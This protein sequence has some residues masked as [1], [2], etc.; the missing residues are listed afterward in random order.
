MQFLLTL[1]DKEKHQNRR[2]RN[3]TVPSAATKRK[4][5]D[6]VIHCYEEQNAGMYSDI[7][8]LFNQRHTGTARK[9]LYVHANTGCK[10]YKLHLMTNKHQ[11]VDISATRKLDSLLD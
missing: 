3:L 1:R 11:Y 7:P 5:S 8:V 9:R 6:D 2:K 10:R 4:F